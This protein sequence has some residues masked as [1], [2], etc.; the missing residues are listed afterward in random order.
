MKRYSLKKMKWRSV[1]A[2]VLVFLYMLPTTIF[3]SGHENNQEKPETGFD[4]YITNNSLAVSPDEKT[5]VVSDSREHII[6]VFDLVKGTLKKKIEGFVTPRNIVFIGGGA[7]FVVSD[8]TL[9]SLR[10][11]DTKTLKLKD[12][13]VVGQ[14]AFGTAVS[15]DGRTM[16]VNNQAQSSVTV[17]DLEK[18]KPVTVI[19]GFSQPRQGIVVSHDGKFVFVTNF[20]GD[21]VSVIDTAAKTIV[22][23]INGFSMIRAISVS[24]DGSTL[25][26]ANSG[27]DSIS[28]VDLAQGE[29]VD[30]I[31]VGREPYGAALSPDGKLLFASNKAD[32]TINVISV[33][34]NRI[35]GTIKGFLE[36]RQAIAFS[37]DGARAYVL[38][39]DLSISKVD[40]NSG[41]IIDTISEKRSYRLQVLK[42]DE[43]GKYLADQEGMTLYYFTK[44]TPGI[45][46]CLGKCLEIW[47]PF[48]AENIKASEGFHKKDFGTITREDGQKQTTYKG[49]PLYYFI[50]DQQPGDTKGQGVN[51]IWYIINKHFMEKSE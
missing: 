15:P 28:V 9:G 8:S 12:E 23:E 3:A 24:A 50:K 48:Y 45:S 22:R 39:R 32:N 18:R 20:K 46:N 51:N 26:A 19:P 2:A 14:G 10:F 29:I 7:Q 47:P 38:N 30:E 36:P 21:K 43:V 40:V 6:L 49:Y 17:V 13:I 25:Y 11:Y 42:S 5:G 34:D 31:K 37:Q 16:Y 1:L 41:T 35:T 27:R 33:S 44:D 4:T